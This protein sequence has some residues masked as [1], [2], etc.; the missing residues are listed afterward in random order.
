MCYV[1][2]AFKNSTLPL[3]PAQ[4]ASRQLR[5]VGGTLPTFQCC[6]CAYEH[7][8]K[9]NHGVLDFWAPDTWA[10]DTWAPQFRYSASG[11]G[12]NERNHSVTEIEAGVTYEK[13]TKNYF[14][15]C[16]LEKYECIHVVRVH[17]Y[18]HVCAYC[19]CLLFHRIYIYFFIE[20]IYIYIYIYI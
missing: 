14:I 13:N 12:I 8:S 4:V 19:I 16:V 17:V 9:G 1:I 10:P 18:I 7:S 20:Y 11:S 2:V 3:H 5:R 15:S 6:R